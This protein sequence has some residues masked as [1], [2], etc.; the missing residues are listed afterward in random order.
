MI[1]LDYK[2]DIYP[3]IRYMDTSLGPNIQPY[4]IGDL[5]H[6]IG[7]DK[8]CKYRL[9]S[10]EKVTRI[11]QSPTECNE[12]GI[13]S[14]C[15]WCSA[16]NYQE[17]G[18]INKRTTYT[19]GMHKARALANA[20]YWNKIFDKEKSEYRFKLNLSDKECLKIISESELKE[21][22]SFMIDNFIPT[23]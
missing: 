14:N 22:K 11:S 2:G 10:F 5:N 20:Y 1:S 18:T 13:N 15:G 4:R 17:F 23:N 6:G 21:I 9:D 3:C 16:L 19:C 8:D 7:F 12:C